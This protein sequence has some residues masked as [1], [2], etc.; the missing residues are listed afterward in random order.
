MPD[1]VA[2]VAEP[3]R[4]DSIPVLPAATVMLVRDGDEGLE[5]FMLQRTHA[6]SFAKGQFVFPGGK[7]DDVDHAD[8]LD[9]VTDGDDVSVSA[10]MGMES[11][12]LAWVV[13]AVRE[14]F[15][16]A[17]VLLARPADRHEPIVFDATNEER[18]GT[19]RRA[20]HA[21]ERSLASVCVEES[22]R[23]LADRVH[24]VDHWI[25]PVGERRRFDTRIFLTTAPEGQAPLHDEVETIASLW[26]RP[27]DALQMWKAGELQMF[28]PTVASVRFL[29]AHD[30]VASAVAAAAEVGVPPVI[31]PKMIV[32]ES[33]RIRGV[34]LPGDPDYDT[35]PEP[36]HLA[37]DTR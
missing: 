26:V 24:L 15:E 3:I 7:V 19:H 37:S 6:A 27:A 35:T 25:T 2:E 23:I 10:R 29:A 4:A 1:T 33:G 11:G 17:G 28:P 12:G 36:V 20:V 14:C 21:G 31:L 16:E 8:A 22:L 30:T 9:P 5:V 32:D 34:R 13:A 18:F